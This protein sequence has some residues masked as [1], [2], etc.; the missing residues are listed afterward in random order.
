MTRI[1]K[2]RIIR[3]A[4]LSLA[5]AAG[6]V[7]GTANYA[8]AAAIND[9]ASL[10]AEIKDGA[11]IE[12]TEGN[13]GV[14]DLGGKK[15]VTIEDKDGQGSNFT[16]IYVNNTDGITLR[17]LTFNGGN[18]NNK[19]IDLGDGSVSKLTVEN[20]TFGANYFRHIANEDGKGSLS[21]I[22]ISGNHFDTVTNNSVQLYA[23]GDT[24][25]VTGNDFRETLQLRGSEGKLLK[26]V[27]VA[28][29][30]GTYG[31]TS[32]FLFSFVD[33][34]TVDGNTLVQH[35]NSSLTSAVIQVSSGSSNVTISNNNLSGEFMYGVMFNN[36]LKQGDVNY[37]PEVASSNLRI[38]SGNTIKGASVGAVTVSND[39]VIKHGEKLYVAKGNTFE[40][41]KG[42]KDF[43]DAS[44]KDLSTDSN[45]IEDH[46]NDP[47]PEPETPAVT[48]PT[49]KAKES[50]VA[51]PNT[52]V[53][54]VAGSVLAMLTAA[55]TI[56]AA[57]FVGVRLANRK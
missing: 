37:A 48:V 38:E 42:G 33:G 41:A 25:T 54:S 9:Q 30:T 56:L 51:A 2:S 12:L 24:V 21:N 23:E 45:L 13:F 34:L 4:V 39:N 1:N 10:Q 52:G 36:N 44:G 50:K 5:V 3:S 11:T 16:N 18:G 35:K 28:G 47:E 8:G 15:N 55:T 14:I 20:S 40:N 46:R 49:S 27:H 31:N 43:V 57:G 29:N 7:L 26:N 6:G 53:Q 19:A 32:P 17:G 22:T